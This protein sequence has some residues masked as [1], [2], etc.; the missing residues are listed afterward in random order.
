MTMRTT[1]C[2]ILPNG[3][4]HY[5]VANHIKQ[6]TIDSQYVVQLGR[7]HDKD[8]PTTMFQLVAG[9]TFYCNMSSVGSYVIIT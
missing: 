5:N 2:I 8:V 7:Y 4:L 1:L 6:G 9:V 3:A